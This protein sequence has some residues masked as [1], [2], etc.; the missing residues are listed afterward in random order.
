MRDVYVVGSYTT[1]FKK[2]PGMSWGD[3]A[4]EAYLGTLSD[5]GMKNG[6]EAGPTPGEGRGEIALAENGGGVIGMEE[7]V[8]SVVILQERLMSDSELAGIPGC[9]ILDC[10]DQVV[11]RSQ[12]SGVFRRRSGSCLPWLCRSG[13]EKTRGYSC[14]GPIG[15][16]ASAASQSA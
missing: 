3:L 1:A 13:K 10:H 2:H 5:A 8:A 15:R 9:G 4:R 16:P 11:W 14:R 12:D 7:A 6:A